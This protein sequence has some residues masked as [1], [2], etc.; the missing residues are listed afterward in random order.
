MQGPRQGP[1]K[2]NE[3]AEAGEEGF[4]WREKWCWD[5]LSL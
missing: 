5:P 4:L 1:G 2:G 3:K